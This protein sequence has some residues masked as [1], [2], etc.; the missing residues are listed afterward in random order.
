MARSATFSP[1]ARSTPST[2]PVCGYS[3]NI[4]LLKNL[5]FGEPAAFGRGQSVDHDDLLEAADS[6]DHLEKKKFFFPGRL[7]DPPSLVPGCFASDHRQSSRIWSRSPVQPDLAS[8]YVP[9]SG[10][11]R[12][13]P[14][15]ESH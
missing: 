10:G 1:I 8:T 3:V 15:C 12:A 7:T 11:P 13:P 5:P 14:A 4:C 6:F 2:E 9:H